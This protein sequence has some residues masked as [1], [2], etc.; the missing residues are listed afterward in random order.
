[1]LALLPARIYNIPCYHAEGNDFVDSPECTDW[2]E[3]TDGER[4]SAKPK[5]K[6]RHAA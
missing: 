3:A 1:M 6:K 2:L 5:N 4:E